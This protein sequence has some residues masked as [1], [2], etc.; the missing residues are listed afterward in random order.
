MTHHATLKQ[1]FHPRRLAARPH[2]TDISPFAKHEIDSVHNNR[3]PRA[4]LAGQHSQAGTELQLQFFHER[5]VSYVKVTEHVLKVLPAADTCHPD[6]IA[7][8]EQGGNPS[9]P[10]SYES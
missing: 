7:R 8:H 4:S 1:R 6:T 5:E 10:H 3:L 2:Q 9:K